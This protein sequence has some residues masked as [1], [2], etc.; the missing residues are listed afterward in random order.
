[1]INSQI[2]VQVE[3]RIV[4]FLPPHTL[5]DCVLSPRVAESFISD[6]VHFPVRAPVGANSTGRRIISSLVYV[7]VHL[8]LPA[9]RVVLGPGVFFFG[10]KRYAA[11]GDTDLQVE[12]AI[13]SDALKSRS[14][15][16]SFD[17]EE[18]PLV[19]ESNLSL[20]SPLGC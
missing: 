4:F 16:V 8:L 3:K 11:L 17:F 7:E 19:K 10:T 13:V 1:M 6:Q 15:T 14:F 5:D 18:D 20:H 2:L 12:V 9:K